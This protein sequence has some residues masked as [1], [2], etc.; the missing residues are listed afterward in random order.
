M[1]NRRVAAIFFAGL[2]AVSC[3]DETKTERSANT[4]VEKAEAENDEHP[5]EDEI[6]EDCV[7][8]VRATQVVSPATPGP[9]C[10][11]CTAVAGAVEVLAFRELH[12]DKISCAG[13][14]CEV[15]VT[16]RAA[17]NSAPPGTITGGLAAWFS[18]EQRAAYLSGQSPAGD[19]IFPVKVIYKRRP[20]GWR[21]VEFDKAN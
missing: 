5:R 15:T 12:A 18:Q 4:Q 8:F 19:Q 13:D 6:A 9:D 1:S 16:I 17:F 11:N 7:G 10:A 3:S 20:K 21:A 2:L 14:T